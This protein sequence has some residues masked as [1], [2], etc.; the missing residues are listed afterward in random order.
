MFC[1]KFHVSSQQI[2][3]QPARPQTLHVLR[4]RISCVD[5]RGVREKAAAQ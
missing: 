4:Q 2:Q 1:E 3:S 5:H